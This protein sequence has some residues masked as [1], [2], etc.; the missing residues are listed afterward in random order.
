MYIYYHL[1][2]MSTL[3]LQTSK[4][5]NDMH[6]WIHTKFNRYMTTIKR[7]SNSN[8][9]VNINN[10]ISTSNITF[11]TI[12]NKSLLVHVCIVLFIVC[13]Y[14]CVCE[15]L[16]QNNNHQTKHKNN[17]T[18]KEHSCRSIAGVPFD[19]VRRFRATL[20][21]RTTCMRR[22]VIELLA[23]W[24]HYK[25]KT[26]NQKPKRMAEN[27][28]EPR[29]WSRVELR[30]CVWKLNTQ[31]KHKKNPDVDIWIYKTLCSFPSQWISF[32]RLILRLD[33]SY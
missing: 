12:Q 4:L 14:I 22:W 5:Y 26:K 11:I 29:N 18:S 24:R 28:S 2:R 9:H 16:L 27:T 7:A 20:L 32:N 33:F 1:V 6:V 10:E 30:M 21:L 31:R 25:P 8:P 17:T 19:S 13:L 3:V 23:V 15:C